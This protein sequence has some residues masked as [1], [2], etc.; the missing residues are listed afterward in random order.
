MDLASLKNSYLEHLEIEKGRSPLTIR[1]YDHYLRTFF[2][3]CEKNTPISK[4]ADISVDVVRKFRIHLSRQKNNRGDYLAPS[5]QNYYVI[6]LRNFLKFLAKQDIK[7]LSP[8]KLELRRQTRPQVSVLDLGKLEKMLNAA[9]PDGPDDL[10]GLRDFAMLHTLFSTGLRV[11]ELVRVNR[12]Q[13]NLKTREFTI[14]G[15]GNKDRVVF[16]SH[17]A[18]SVI[19]DYLKKRK[20]SYVPL[21]LNHRGKADPSDKRG[22]TLRLTSRTIQRIIVKNARR[23]GIVE[24]I[25]PHTLRHTFATDLLHNGA[26][27]RSVQEMLGH[28]SI[29]T[30]QIYTHVTN[31]QLKEVHEAF[32]SKKKK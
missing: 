10:A 15:K 11:G 9:K 25:T 18:A 27:L 17:D 8:D 31:R 3:W 28:S 7:T 13:I 26:D 16:L 30:T 1:D 19:T 22:E 12:D 14:R 23:A 6:A 20:D 29:Q 2:K 4:P 24:H 5:T 32:H 21:F